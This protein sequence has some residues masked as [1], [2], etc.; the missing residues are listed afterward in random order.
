LNDIFS[1]KPRLFE[2]RAQ[3]GGC[4]GLLNLYRVLCHVLLSLYSLMARRQASAL[5]VPQ[6]IFGAASFY[7]CLRL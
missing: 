4:S 6:A 1:L 5:S 2:I 7:L 3:T